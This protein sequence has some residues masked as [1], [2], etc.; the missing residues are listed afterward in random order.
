MLVGY[1]MIANSSLHASFA[2]Y[3]L[4]FN[5]HPYVEYLLNNC[6]YMYVTV[7]GMHAGL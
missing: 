5:A 7:E 4:I 3:H 2:I 6:R 1:E